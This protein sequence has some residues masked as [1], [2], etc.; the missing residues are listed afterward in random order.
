MLHMLAESGES[1][2]L[3]TWTFAESV[4]IFHSLGIQMEARSYRCVSLVA[5]AF[6]RMIFQIN[7]MSCN[8]MRFI[9]QI[10]QF[11]FG[12]L[13]HWAT[14]CTRCN[15]FYNLGSSFLAVADLRPI[16]FPLTASQRL[17]S[18]KQSLLPAVTSISQFSCKDTI[19]S[20][21][22]SR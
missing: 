2:W 12:S 4:T 15:I 8:K 11:F 21:S 17:W 7:T 13:H 19:D 1:C 9:Y 18:M 3:L 16:S 6:H 14:H 22:H 5:G 10:N 20:S